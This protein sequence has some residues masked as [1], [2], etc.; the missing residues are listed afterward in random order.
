V[1]PL[2][3]NLV[4]AVDLSVVNVVQGLARGKYTIIT[5]QYLYFA[6]IS[7]VYVCCFS[8]VL[9]LPPPGRYVFMCLFV[10]LMDIP[11]GQ[12]D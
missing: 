6:S 4:S 8:F 3:I 1:F 5:R 9:Y 11:Q 10:G 7:L 2:V 12:I